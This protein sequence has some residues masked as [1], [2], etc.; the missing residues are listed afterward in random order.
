VHQSCATETNESVGPYGKAEIRTATSADTEAV[1]QCAFETYSR[2]NE[3]FGT[4]PAPHLVQLAS[5][6]D[7]GNVAVLTLGGTLIGYIVYYPGADH[8]HLENVGVLP[9]FNGR[10]YGRRLIEH[11][12]QAAIRNGLAAVEL[13]TNEKMVEN[14]AMYPKLGYTE[15]DRRIDQ[16]YSR[17]FFRKTLNPGVEDAQ[18]G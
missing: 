10:G 7:C 11:V 18:R 17:V 6:I 4:E 3:R 1:E 12:E 5:A 9:R 13:Y 8:M 14:I 2:Y 16:G 15:V